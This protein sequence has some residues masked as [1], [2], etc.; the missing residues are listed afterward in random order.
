M[1]FVNLGIGELES[2][3][4]SLYAVRALAVSTFKAWLDQSD[5]ALGR[6]YSSTHPPLGI[7]LMTA[8]RAVF[9]ESEFATRLPSAL[10]GVAATLALFALLRRV[11]SDRIALLLAAGFASCSLFSWFA[12]HA[13]L[14]SLVIALG[15][16]AV[17]I[18]HKSLDK[19]SLRFATVS[20][21]LLGLALMSK[22]IWGLFVLPYVIVVVI[23]SKEEIR[24]KAIIIML[25]VAAVIALPWHL[26]M[27]NLHP[28]FFTHVRDS[29][30]GISSVTGYEPGGDRSIVY[31][32]NQV[33][34]NVPFIV[35]GLLLYKK[36]RW[37][38]VVV[39]TLIWFTVLLIGL[40]LMSTKMPHF[41]LL[42]LPAAVLLSGAVIGRKSELP[43]VMW[44]VL[45]LAVLWSLSA[46]VRLLLKGVDFE[47]ILP[48]TGSIAIAT[49]VLAIIAGLAWQS[50]TRSELLYLILAGLF[51][52]SASVKVLN[53][54]EEVFTDGA[55]H[56]ATTL[57]SQPT[58]T[59]L[60]SL[61]TS[62]PSDDLAPRLA[63][64][65][66][67]WT[68]G[69][70]PGKTAS[71]LHWD[72]DGVRDS[73]NTRLSNNTA[74]IIERDWDRFYVPSREVT[75]RMTELRSLLKT[76]YANYDSL[77]S[78]DFFY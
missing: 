69:W 18:L 31:Y 30:F 54:K 51:V 16:W 43:I 65:T 75:Q 21:L 35:L 63:Y 64:Y 60:V 59:N 14:D 70:I 8:S 76:R 74:V 28:D 26:Y 19:Q 53:Y 6:F 50:R 68:R 23:F 32:I 66:E 71:A 37:S 45:A 42:L 7:W 25:G 12:R 9:G 38:S 33:I 56:I 52:L 49:I 34:I 17:V 27:L 22:F 40:Q 1:L 73:L 36:E 13:Q 20:G 3:D 78:Y 4:E 77:R 61:H 24:Y 47:F 44:I 5:Y 11:T 57:G 15:L 58:I 41:A 72:N 29:L 2:S 55:R 39:A 46:Q 48:G 10:A 67:G 62:L